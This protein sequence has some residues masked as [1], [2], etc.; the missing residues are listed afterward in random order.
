MGMAL[1]TI[2]MPNELR[3]PSMS[4]QMAAIPFFALAVAPVTVSMLSGVLGGTAAIGQPL[5]IVCVT[6]FLL[7]AGAFALGRRYV[8]ARTG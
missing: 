5:T 4:M 7:A 2:V 1:F 6:A 8:P 3:G